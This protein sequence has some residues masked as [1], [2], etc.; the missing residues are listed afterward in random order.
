MRKIFLVLALLLL[1]SPAVVSAEKLRVIPS[2]ERNQTVDVDNQTIIPGLNGDLVIQDG[3]K[4]EKEKDKKPSSSNNFTDTDAYSDIAVSAWDKIM[5]HMADDIKGEYGDTVGF[6]FSFITWNVKPWEIVSIQELEHQMWLMI[7]PISILIV[8]SVMVA[9]SA[10][11]ADPSGYKTMFGNV[12]IVHNDFLGGGLFV[13]IALASEGTAIGIILALDLINAFLMSSILE[14]IRPSLDTATMYLALGVIEGVLFIFF[15]YRQVMIVAMYVIAPIY[16][17]FF[18]T[19][20]FKEAVDEIGDK[21]TK[22]LLMQPLCIFLT[23]IAIKVMEA[24][25]VHFFGIQIY[26]AKD[27]GIFYLALFVVLLFACIW[28]LFTKVN[29]FKRIVGIAVYR[30]I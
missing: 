20:L 5:I 7:F 11:L 12:D 18:A 23:N 6:I 26:D 27:G 4:E 16:G 9:R 19:G 21:F 29:F 25:H 8:L 10:A 15:F 3:G 2:D 17:L 1:L 13:I 22:A 28:C 24:A 30:R 14:S